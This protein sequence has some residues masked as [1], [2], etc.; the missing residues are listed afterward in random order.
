MALPALTRC[1][2]GEPRHRKCPGPIRVC[3]HWGGP[4][5]TP[6]PNGP[7]PRTHKNPGRGDAV[8]NHLAH[9]PH[10]A[11]RSPHG[12]WPGQGLCP[13]RH[14]ARL[15]ARGAAAYDHLRCL[16]CRLHP[17]P[18]GEFLSVR[19]SRTTQQGKLLSRIA[20]PGQSGVPMVV[21]RRRRGLPTILA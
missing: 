16:T 12:R 6:P 11:T 21:G 14:A 20:V 1:R 5:C 8:A 17:L 10:G 4:T 7:G 13:R 9:R 19:C 2:P 15:T 18:V 3:L